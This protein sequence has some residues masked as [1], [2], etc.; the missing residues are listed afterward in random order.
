M[1]SFLAI[2]GFVAVAAITPGPNNFVVLGTASRGG[3]AATLPAITGVVTGSLGLLCVVSAGA[4]IAFS[5]EPRLRTALMVAGC[6]Y[7]AWLGASLVWRSG[8]AAH[9][10]Q[11]SNPALPSGVVGLA[12]F[13]FLNPKSWLLVMTATAAVPAGLSWQASLSALALIFVVVTCACLTLWASAGA[14]LAGLLKHPRPRR[15]YDRAM[16]VTLIA[17]AAVLVL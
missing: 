9:K 7:L 17:S 2:I 5:A 13:Q 8:G 10:V 12:V 16:G 3:F 11:H 4:G 6:L 15:W 1:E 14:A